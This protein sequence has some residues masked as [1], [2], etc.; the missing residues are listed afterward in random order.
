MNQCSNIV[1]GTQSDILIQIFL[2]HF[3]ETSKVSIF[4]RYNFVFRNKPKNLC[5]SLGKIDT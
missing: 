4:R 5:F 1:P 3:W 2:I